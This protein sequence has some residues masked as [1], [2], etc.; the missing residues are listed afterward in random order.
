MM[1]K[2]C[3][4]QAIIDRVVRRQGKRYA[5]DDVPPEHTALIVIDMQNYFMAPGEQAEVP[6]ARAIV[7]NVNRLAKSLRDNG[8]LV[9]WVKTLAKEEACAGWSHFHQVLLT[10]DRNARR[11]LSLRAG[12]PAADLWPELEIDPSDPIVT[13][14]RYSA[15]ISGSSN[16]EAVLRRRGIIGVW[17]AGTTTNTCCESTARDAMMLDFR[18]TIVS[19]ATATDTDMEHNATLMNFYNDF[20]DVVSTDELIE[21]L[22]SSTRVV[23]LCD[24][25]QEPYEPRSQA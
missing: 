15:L 3:I 24:T 9:V 18:T 21:R 8:G 5:H 16:L 10:A 1:H 25:A 14:T 22:R 17:I 13:K 12:A 20:G 19:D 6:M 7:G 23:S 11:N 2:V 4:P